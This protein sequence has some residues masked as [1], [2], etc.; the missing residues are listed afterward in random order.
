MSDA[1][2]AAYFLAGLVAVFVLAYFVGTLLGPAVVDEPAPS[3][4]TMSAPGGTP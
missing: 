3:E 4:H 1:T 2:R